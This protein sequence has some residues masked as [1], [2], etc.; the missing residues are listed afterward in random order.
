MTDTPVITLSGLSKN[1]GKY[2]ALDQL[3]LTLEPNKIYGLLGRN[4][5]GKTTLLNI[6]SARI[7][8]SSGDYAVFGESS[9]ENI[10]ILRQICYVEEKGLY[11]RE[12]RVRQ[13]LALTSGL[14]PN[15]DAAFAQELLET[16][17]LNPKKKFKQLSRGMESA[18]GLVIGLASRAPLTIFDE[19]SLGL[20]AVIRERFYDIL[21]EDYAL[22][23]R[24]IVIS[25]HLID[26]VSR[27]F[28][29]IIL[30]DRGHILLHK[31]ENELRE[32]AFYL[33]GKQ[34]AV[35]A[36]AKDCLVLHE[37]QFG[38]T[39]IL[40][41]YTRQKPRIGEDVEIQP[42]P[43]QKLFTYLIDPANQDML[44]KGGVFA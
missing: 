5:A 35:W 30:L 21:L 26:E 31:P 12:L 41:V 14:Y 40:G 36:A 1:F 10:K 15:W 23:P 16:F 8:P 6:L 34:D 3:Q 28:E 42:I 18:L 24:T 19:P 27:M 9:Y 11:H 25:T 39:L 2:T 32:Q 17:E 33:S 29:N 13:A 37:E 22:H 43:M 4:G 44:R 38:G 20:D 7:F